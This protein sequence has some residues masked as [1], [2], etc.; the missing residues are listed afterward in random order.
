MHGPAEDM[1]SDEA[2]RIGRLG[3]SIFSKSPRTSDNASI[4]IRDDVEVSHIFRSTLAASLIS[5]SS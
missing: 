2:N 5:D 3:A 1:V 4:L